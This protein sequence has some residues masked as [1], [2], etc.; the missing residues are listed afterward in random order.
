M[1]HC[2]KLVRGDRITI[3][4]VSVLGEE[5][6]CA[7]ISEVSHPVRVLLHP[8]TTDIHLVAYWLRVQDLYECCGFH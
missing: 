5:H 6:S 7:K 2:S 3:R 4:S 1:E 8:R